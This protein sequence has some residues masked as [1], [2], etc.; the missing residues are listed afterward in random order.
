[1]DRLETAYPEP[2]DRRQD[3]LDDSF[4]GGGLAVHPVH[5]GG[6][7]EPGREQLM[8]ELHEGGI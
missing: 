8:A 1:V 2:G 4:I 3:A 7:E 6:M 5:R